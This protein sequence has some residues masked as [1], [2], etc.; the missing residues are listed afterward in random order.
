VSALA[1]QILASRQ[2]VD[3]DGGIVP[4]KDETPVEQCEFLCS[5]I[6][7]I[8]ARVCLEVG[9]AQGIST[10]FL[11]DAIAG[12]PGARFIS[13][14]RYQRGYRDIGLLNLERAGYK[15]FVEFHRNFSYEVLPKLLADGL[16][17]DFAYVDSTK[18]FDVLLV[19]AFYLSRLL[20]VGGVMVFDDCRYFDGPR[21]LARYLAKWPNLR[22]FATHGE[23][24]A[25]RGRKYALAKRLVSAL[26][27]G[28]PVLSDEAAVSAK[29]LQVNAQCIA[30]EKIAEDERKYDWYV[31]F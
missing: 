1:R 26:P 23:Y 20:R 3:A 15:D 16:K 14:D 17:L 28:R 25:G 2:I 18:L 7:R 4:L 24:D 27:G 12:K 13:I 19:D 9:L 5:L 11:C 21:R 6:S 8:D 29:S 10:L 30:F 22:V 31:D